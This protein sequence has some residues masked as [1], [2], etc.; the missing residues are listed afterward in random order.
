MN[1]NYSSLVKRGVELDYQIKQ[2]TKELD[3]IKN[4]LK[5]AY[6]ESGDKLF[7]S[8]DGEACATLVLKSRST[9]DTRRFR[10]AMIEAGWEDKIFDCVT[11]TRNKAENYLSRGVLKECTI[12]EDVATIAISFSAAK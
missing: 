3:D 12:T 9:I 7:M 4:S 10:R 1:S 2:M 11:V 8:K 5:E 6:A